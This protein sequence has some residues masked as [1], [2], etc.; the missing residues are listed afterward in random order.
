MSKVTLTLPSVGELDTAAEPKVTT[1]LK[2]LEEFLNGAKIESTD[3]IKAEGITEA[4]LS[5]AIK[6]KLGGSFVGL[7]VSEKTANFEGEAGK[8]YKVAKAC[9]ATLPAATSGRTIG[10]V[11]ATSAEAVKVSAKAGKQIIGGFFEGEVAE[12]LAHQA[13]IVEA[14]GSNWYIIAGEPKREQ[15][16]EAAK[17]FT[18]AELKA[19]I[20]VSAT[21][22]A[23]VYIFT[24]AL[25][26]IEVD[27]VSVAVQNGNALPYIIPA[28]KK[29]AA[30]ASASTG[31]YAALL[32]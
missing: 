19:G 1:A 29:F 5:P 13:I 15:K 2:A 4:S 3:N 25:T 7:A 8:L 22:L 17:A 28:G 10:I 32:L 24:S 9:T 12:L 30:P 27:G 16:Y 6:T 18:N 21:R 23:F 11:N 26:T 14:D 31:T 20:E